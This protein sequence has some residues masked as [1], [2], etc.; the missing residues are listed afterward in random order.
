MEER[1]VKHSSFWSNSVSWS[2]APGRPLVSPLGTGSRVPSFGGCGGEAP[3]V[4]PTVEMRA[5]RARPSPEE[6]VGFEHR[7]PGLPPPMEVNFWA[8]N[9]TPRWGLMPEGQG[10]AAQIP[11]IPAQFLD[12]KFLSVCFSQGPPD[13]PTCCYEMLGSGESEAQRPTSFFSGMKVAGLQGTKLINLALEMPVTPDV[14]SPL[15]TYIFLNSR[16]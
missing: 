13:W 9:L 6:H 12:G 3:D 2:P 14:M 4:A 7:T 5:G 15:C 10:Q 16:T 8:Q 11:R 1:R